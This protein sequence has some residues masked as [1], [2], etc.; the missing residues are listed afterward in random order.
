MRVNND[1][2]IHVMETVV[3]P[4][5]EG[6]VGDTNYGFQQDGS[7]TH[8]ANQ[9]KAWLEENLKKLWTKNIWPPSSRNCNPCDY[10]L[11]GVCDRDINKHP[12]ST[13]AFLNAE[14]TEVMAGLDKAILAKT[15]RRFRSQIEQILGTEGGFIE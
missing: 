14:V 12:H 8:N 3:K 10:F 4:W 15:C 13:K 2:Y 11:C 6:I 7:P 5:V 9:L 1:A